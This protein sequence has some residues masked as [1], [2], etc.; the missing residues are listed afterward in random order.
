MNKKRLFFLL[1]LISFLL[2][3]LLLTLIDKRLNEILENYIDAEVDKIT[4]LVIGNAIK[5]TPS[6]KEM[7]N[8]LKVDRNEKNEIEKISYDTAEINKIKIDLTNNIQ[9]ELNE[10]EVGNLENYPFPQQAKLR[11]KYNYIKSGYICE[12]NLNSISFSTLFG[13]LGPSIPIKLSFM[14][15]TQVEL[16]VNTKE[17]GINNVLIEVDAVVTIS[18][19]ITMPISSKTHT[20]VRKEPISIEIIK[21]AIPNYYSELMK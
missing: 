4:S 8:F 5:N 20:I 18:N 21:G 12:V 6:T 16:E 3:F 19:L 13:N 15:Y 9:K 7:K 11:N 10:I 1:L 17:Y 14:G 2:S